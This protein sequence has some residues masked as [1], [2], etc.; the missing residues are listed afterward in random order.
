MSGPAAGTGDTAVPGVGV[1]RCPTCV[2][3]WLVVGLK[4]GD[5]HICKSCGCEFAVTR[6]LL[7][8]AADHSRARREPEDPGLPEAGRD[9]PAG[10][11]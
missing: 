10:R 1:I 4:A 6:S 5:R 9:E 3:S 8:N 2:R 7:A 11:D